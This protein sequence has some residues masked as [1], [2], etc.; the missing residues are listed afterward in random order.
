MEEVGVGVGWGGLGWVGLGWV[1]LGWGEG[2]TAVADTPAAGRPGCC[3]QAASLGPPSMPPWRHPEGPELTSLCLTGHWLDQP[4][5]DGIHT[6]STTHISTPGTA[7]HGLQSA[8]SKSVEGADTSTT[9]SGSQ[10]KHHV[11]QPVQL[12]S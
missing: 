11:Q 4:P 12:Q 5:T 9:P 8:N 10:H 3:L 1:G 6:E 7:T 2:M